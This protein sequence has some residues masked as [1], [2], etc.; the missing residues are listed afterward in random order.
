MQSKFKGIAITAVC[1]AWLAACGNHAPSFYEID[2]AVLKERILYQ[3]NTIGVRVAGSDKESE[4]ADYIYRQLLSIGFDEKYVTVQPFSVESQSI[5]SKN[6]LAKINAGG[7]KG[8]LAVVAHLATV[9]T[10]LGAC[11]NEASVRDLL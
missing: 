10:T 5:E 3:T 9:D 1:V 7:S 2:S 6:V 8:I 11:H 4:T